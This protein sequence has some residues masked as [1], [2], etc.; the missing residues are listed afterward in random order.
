MMP[1]AYL[2]T[3]ALITV[4]PLISAIVRWRFAW[5][6]H[7]WLRLLQVFALVSVPFV[8]LDSLSHARG[9]WAYNPDFVMGVRL[10]GLPVEEIMFFFVVP[11]ACL[12]L[13]SAMQR[14]APDVPFR[15]AWLWRG[16]IGLAVVAGIIL[17]IIEPKERTIFDAVLFAVVGTVAMFR[18][19]TRTTAIW[20]LLVLGLFLV[21]NTVLTALPIVAYD[22]TFGSMYRIG[23]IP[24][25]DALYNLSFLLLSLGVW[26]AEPVKKLLQAA[27]RS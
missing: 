26:N 2:A 6:K 14:A 21:V 1:H 22:A 7:D 8:L 12:Y 17:A 3:L 5:A 24:F 20:L 11:F 19:P 9:W 13:Y 16:V 10:L 27:H 15:R 4:M 23:T 18:R 25:E